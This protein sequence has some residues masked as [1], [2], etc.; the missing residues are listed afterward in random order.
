MACCGDLSAENL[1]EDATELSLLVRGGWKTILFNI[2]PVVRKQ[3]EPLELSGRQ[4]DRG[5][6]E[7]SLQKA[8]QEAHFVPASPYCWKSSTH[9]P[10]LKLLHAVGTLKGPRLDSLRLL[11]QVNCEEWREE[12]KKGGLTFD[13]LKMV[14]LWSTELF[15]SQEDWQD[16]EGSVYR[17]LVILLCCLATQRL[18]HFLHPEENLFQGEPLDLSSLYCKVESFARDPC[19]FL[20][21]H[22]SLPVYTDGLQ[23]DPGIKALLQLPAKDRAYWD[24][25]YFDI[26]LSQFQ[27]YRIQDC[28]RRLAMSQLLSKVRREVPVQS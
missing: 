19:R 15:P 17:L 11:D 27:V 28:A 7:G 8:T 25:A 1:K 24:T 21:F 23:A 13:H 5:F 9:L 16:L 26:L 10:V 22:F 12:G 14:L 2:V 20:R 18:P 3:Q 6:P 4:S